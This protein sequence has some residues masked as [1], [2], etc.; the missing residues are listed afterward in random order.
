MGSDGGGRVVEYRMELGVLEAMVRFLE[1]G[2]IQMGNIV[3]GVR[4]ASKPC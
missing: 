2:I 3:G 1:C 4:C